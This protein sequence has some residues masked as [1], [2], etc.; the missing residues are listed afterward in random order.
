[1]TELSIK[2]FGKPEI[3]VDQKLIS[4]SLKRSEA[5]VYYLAYEKRVSRDV[6]V[7]CLWEDLSV[8]V[9][10]KNLRNSLYRIKKDLNVELFDS[11]NKNLVAWGADLK[12]CV[13][14]DCDDIS[15]LLAYEGSFLEG[16]FLKNAPRF[17]NWRQETEMLLNQKFKQLVDKYLDE[18]IFLR[19][20]DA[21][22]AAKVLYKMDPFDE[23]AVRLL[24]RVY[25]EKNMYKPIVEVYGALKTLL[26]EEMG[27]KPD[28]KTRNL[29]YELIQQRNKESVRDEIFGREKE[30][31][32]LAQK[33]KDYEK[34]KKTF[35][36]FLEGE[37]GVGKTKV[38]SSILSDLPNHVT[39]VESN[40][41]LDEE[42]FAYKPW[43][44]IL[45]KLIETMRSEGDSSL[46]SA[47]QVLGKVFPSVLK[48]EDAPF[49]E[50]RE[51]I[52]SDFV[53]R[54]VYSII[55]EYTKKHRLVIVFEDLQW[56]DLWSLK[57]LQN[58]LL[59]VEGV[60]VLGTLRKVALEKL[61][62]L[63]A[64]LYKYNCAYTLSLE[65]FTK[66]E[67]L[68]FLKEGLKLK[69][70]QRDLEKIYEET[71]GNAFFVVEYAGY[72]LRHDTTAQLRL[73]NVMDARLMEVEKEAQKV[74]DILSMF[75]DGVEH[76]FLEKLYSQSSDQLLE[77]L[78][79]LRSRDFIE[80]VKGHS[81]PKWR[82]THHMLRN[83]VYEKTSFSTK[84]VLHR[85]IA[86][87]LE[88]RLTGAQKDVL[89]FQKLMYHYEES[90]DVGKRLAYTIKYLKT[91]FDFS[92]EL[93]PEGQQGYEMTLDFSPEHYFEVL[94]KLFDAWDE[95]IELSIKEE[96]LHMKA[97]YYIRSGDYEVGLP[98]LDQLIDLCLKRA[99]E[100]LLFK[101][102]VQYVYYFIQTEQV[103]QMKTILGKMDSL[104]INL[105]QEAMLMRLRG[106]ERLLSDDY[107]MARE[108]FRASIKAFESLAQTKTYALNIA[109]A[110]NYISE[111]YLKEG[112]FDKALEYVGRAILYCKNYHILRG[113]SIFNTNAGIIAY[114]MNDLLLAKEYF[115]EAM[116]CFDVVDS[117]W[118]KSEAEGY[119]GIIWMKE[120]ESERGMS[121]IASAR[122]R[123]LKMGTPKTIELI[124]SLM[125][126]A[127]KLKML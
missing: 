121:L 70:N 116:K 105:K 100:E 45:G 53:E 91:Y 108:K 18:W 10:K 46:E 61:E 11:P 74:L 124:E 84:R 110:Y 25:K 71:Q 60:F 88:K 69:H 93:Y 32:S 44:D 13:D 127:D 28:A 65:R 92:H 95:G 52:R 49:V 79:V 41:Y 114:T 22:R 115:E 59:H 19:W 82:F 122:E 8:E 6:L 43:N 55:G 26:E 113:R 85:K 72:Y 94:E 3:K 5:L 83:H 21:L 34:T 67:T 23:E 64:T 40:C 125:K 66:E 48:V 24:M 77:I 96:Y 20:E 33:L 98:A 27:I 54:T 37:A 111:T 86:A 47:I 4:L 35:A 101:A 102:Y 120:G 90:G 63:F 80:E 51:T 9:A 126:E 12:W 104:S 56:M 87:L 58:V 78:E 106:I 36:C 42:N 1:M 103:D 117:P 50:N 81:I 109:A 17:E 14:V 118:K 119:L 30:L 31:E 123:A 112:D 76:S 15:F 99:D 29:Y 75:F 16:F 57:L 97:R 39:L 7:E 2:L 73:K 89:I 68:S 107:K 62:H 38:L